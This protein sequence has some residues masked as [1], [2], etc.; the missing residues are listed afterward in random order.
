[1]TASRPGVFARLAWKAWLLLPCAFAASVLLGYVV[2][3]GVLWSCQICQSYFIFEP[4]KTFLATPS[5]YSFRVI[6]VAIP[7]Q[8]S[9]KTAPQSLHGWWIPS[10]KRD[11]K[12]VLYLHGNEGNMSTNMGEIAPLRELGYSIFMVDYRGYGESE[13]SFPSEKSV[14]ED[15]EVAW[16]YLVRQRG[17][18][19]ADLYIYGHSLG[20]AIAIELALHHPE[21]AGLIVTSSFT[22]IS[23]M[24]NLKRPYTLFPVKLLLNQRFDSISKVGRLK[25]PVL[26]IHGTADEVVPF[27]MGEQL[28][29][30]S[31]GAKRFVAIGGGRHDGNAAVD[32]AAFRAAISSF[33]EASAAARADR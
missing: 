30:A 17:I 5:D 32:A 21:S 29:K 20:G 2:I 18:R 6:V 26:Y 12:V 31:G 8:S 15:A 19:A 14:Y 16:T 3:G 33:I 11:A 10:A 4:E 1:V 9:G 27:A 13:G 7:V 25:L 23:D 22:S 24:A 28:F